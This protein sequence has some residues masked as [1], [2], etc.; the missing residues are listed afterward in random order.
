MDLLAT[1][2]PGG[3]LCEWPLTQDMRAVGALCVA[4]IA[5][6][7]FAAGKAFSPAGAPAGGRG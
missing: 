3:R 5:A 2:P 1:E 4:S 6:L 7:V